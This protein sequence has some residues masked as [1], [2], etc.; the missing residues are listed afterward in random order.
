MKPI[1]RDTQKGLIVCLLTRTV[2]AFFI[3]AGIRAESIGITDVICDGLIMS[4]ITSDLIVA[5]MAKRQLHPWIVIFMMMS[6]FDKFII[7]LS[8]SICAVLLGCRCSSQ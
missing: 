1:Y 8:F 3:Y 2:P 4:I 7:Y 5:K 6:I